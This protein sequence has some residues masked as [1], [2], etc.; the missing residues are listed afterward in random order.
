MKRLI[1]IGCGV[2]EDLD[3]P[4]GDIHTVRLVDMTPNYTTPSGPDQPVE[5]DLCGSCRD[6]LRQEYFGV[7]DVKLLDMPMMKGA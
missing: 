3:N 1:C 2:G 7:S 5:E 6:K 4:A